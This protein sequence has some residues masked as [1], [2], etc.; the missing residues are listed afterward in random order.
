MNKSK[1]Y[2]LDNEGMAAALECIGDG[3]I[4][5]DTNGVINFMNR[6]AELL[7]GWK[8]EE[9]CGKQF[10]KVLPLIDII[11]SEHVVSPINAAVNAGEV[12]GLRNQT[13]F[14]DKEGI[15]KYISATCSPIWD[16]NG[17]INGV[18][19]VFRDI[20]RIK[21]AEEELRKS[22]EKFRALF[23]NSAD[24]I[25]VQ[26]IGENYING[27]LIEVNDTAC[28]MFG[29]S[30]EE[31]FQIS[32]MHLDSG[33]N[34]D[35]LESMVQKLIV[36]NHASFERIGVTKD[37]RYI[38]IEVN[39]HIFTLNG[40][41]IM[42]V[43]FRDISERKEA[44]AAI[45][46][47]RA[48]YQS[49]IMNMNSGFCYFKILEGKRLNP[50][51][52]I[53]VE[54]NDAFEKLTGLNRE[55]ALE[56]SI[57]E[58]CPDLYD[59]FLNFLQVIT[60]VTASKDSYR[61]SEYY[62]KE[63]DKWCS[64]YAYSPEKGYFA[65]VLTDITEE[66]RT[67]EVMKKAR[68]EAES[69]NRAKSEFLANM[70]HE[71]RTPINGMVGMID[72]TMLTQ[73]T[74]E[75]KD[76]LSIAK[77]CANSLLR[78]INDILD[79][80]K[81]EAGK[82]LID[83][84]NFDLNELIE[85]VTRAN[86]TR[87]YDKG[88]E[89]KY[90]F[91]SN[92]PRLLLGD[93]NR[94]K[95]I[96][97]NFISNAIKFTQRGE[98]SVSVKKNNNDGELIE[99]LFSVSDTGI[100]IS[101]NERDMLFKK[102]SQ[103]DSS[104]TRR[105]GGTGLG[106]AISKQLVEMMNGSVWVESE[107][108]KGSTFYFTI[109]LKPGIKQIEKANMNI[110]PKVSKQMSVLL[111]EDDKVN[112]MVTKSM[113]REKGCLV[114]VSNNGLEAV[115]MNE[116]KEYDIILMDIQM[117]EMDGIEATKRIREIEGSKKH[118]PIIALTAYAIHGDRERFI[119]IGM[120]EYLSK[121]FQMDEL[122]STIDRVS[123]MKDNGAEPYWRAVLME[124][125]KARASK[126]ST[127]SIEE[128]TV[129]INKMQENIQELLNVINTN[130]FTIIEMVAHN[131]KELSSSMDAHDIKSIAFKIEL[132]ARRGNLMEVIE[133]SMQIEHEFETYKKSII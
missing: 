44:E 100:G 14:I 34:P 54:I 79:F 126:V 128:K 109:K 77:S 30:R 69:A 55:N 93:P 56:K 1:E 82:L 28:K 74:D 108:D 111:V 132:A 80:S 36:E 61:V 125:E 66:K 59:L 116:S 91:S 19:V 27:R 124:N 63:S 3:V 26:E 81:M 65:I 53:C 103:V 41:Q 38:N 87:A 7:T 11:T 115:A 97:N 4:S 105:F 22:E 110:I 5:T 42:L 76:N 15:K 78:I 51:D 122:F 67:A 133:Y 58:V 49:L 71:I 106:L 102:F 92:L 62:L 119:S 13:V 123:E 2:Y 45:K 99:L 43:M 29:Y 113:L 46:E 127:K 114:D 112:Q 12:V 23:N 17:S 72:L 85:E 70:S 117:P 84:I 60:K 35:E 83:H 107:K 57:L 88:L 89:I 6:T 20:N 120:D 9:V 90:S 50:L 118:T 68:D 10:D 8:F 37:G 32:F 121:P 40:M 129:D 24:A 131:I 75:Q 73:L 64:M 39:C 33:E 48:K 31:F 95:Q 96:L 25:F 18:V 130:N 47:S 101:K 21:T 16:K 86:S 104:I 94:L 98:I 52:C